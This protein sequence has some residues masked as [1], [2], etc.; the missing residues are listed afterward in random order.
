[1][2]KILGKM[3]MVSMLSVALGIIVSL[4]AAGSIQ[5]AQ[6]PARPISLIVPYA[7]GGGSDVSARLIASYAARKLGQPVNVVNIIGASG[8]TGWMQCL[9]AKPDGYTLMIDGIN[10]YLIMASRTDMP[11]TVQDIRRMGQWI[12][13][14]MFFIFSASTPFK[15]LKEAMDFAKAKP[16]EY[17]WGAG[18]QGSQWMFQGLILLNEV[19]VDIAKTKMVVFPGG[20]APSLQAVYAGTVMAGGGLPSDVERLLP[21]GKVKVLAVSSRERVK[22]HPTVPTTREQGYPNAI[23]EAWYG[24]SGSK[25]LPQE[26]LDVWAKLQKDASTDPEFHA[27]AEKMK[28]TLSFQNAKDQEVNFMKEYNTMLKLAEKLGIRK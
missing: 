24:P 27:E 17:S 11:F 25:N 12:A 10:T 8:I 13:D 21:S 7:A 5:A 6:Y 9:S 23:M 2:S 26:V 20:L 3:R 15:T 4:L 28:K 14:P 1:M 16:Q 18:A 19:G 22:N